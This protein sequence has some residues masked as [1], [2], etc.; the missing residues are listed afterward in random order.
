MLSGALDGARHPAFAAAGFSSGGGGGGGI[1]GGAIAGIIIGVLAAIALLA[2]GMWFWLR[3]RRVKR[4][5][6]E[7]AK[8]HDG[9]LTSAATSRN[10]GAHPVLLSCMS[11]SCIAP[12]V[13]AR[14]IHLGLE[15]LPGL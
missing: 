13:V 4:A 1:S 6:L 10:T 5:D 11:A 9:S 14:H 3:R 12:N 7:M 2:I 8:H 15:A